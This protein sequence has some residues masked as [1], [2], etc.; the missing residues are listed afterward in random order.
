MDNTTLLA[1]LAGVVVLALLAVWAAS[2]KR[3]SDSLRTH[4]GSEYDHAV[5]RY[6]GRA[7]AERELETR[8]RRFQK[9]SIRPL[10]DADRERYAQLWQATQARFVDSPAMAVAE[11]DRLI[12]EVMRL[13]GYPVGDVTQRVADVAIGHPH[14]AD[15]YRS[16]Y[17]FSRR[18]KDGKASTEELRQALVHYRA[19]FDD[20][21]VARERELVGAR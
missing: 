18:A 1:A 9:A 10:S 8:E 5:E 11:A 20:L 14:L 12:E 2:R 13:R 19:L 6:G 4:F 21:L 15:H 16:A 17:D 3:R 7:K